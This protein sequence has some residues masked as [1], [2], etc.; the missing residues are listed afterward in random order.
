MIVTNHLTN[1]H[2]GHPASFDICNQS[3]AFDINIAGKAA[4]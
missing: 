3:L 4:D 1:V 2:V